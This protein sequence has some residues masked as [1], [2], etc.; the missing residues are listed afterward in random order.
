MKR[1][2]QKG[3]GV[4]LLS[5]AAVST[6]LCQSVR[7]QGE[8]QDI[9][10]ARAWNGA[11]SQGDRGILWNGSKDLNSLLPHEDRL[12]SW[13]ELHK[14]HQEKINDWIDRQKRWEELRQ[15]RI[16]T[17]RDF[18]NMVNEGVNNAIETGKNFE[19]LKS[20]QL[21]T[22]RKAKEVLPLVWEAKGNT[23]EV[24]GKAYANAPIVIYDA[25]GQVIGRGAAAGDGTFSCRLYRPLRVGERIQ[26]VCGDNGGPSVFYVISQS[27]DSSGNIPS[28]LQQRI[29]YVKGYPDGTFRPSANVTRG[30][31]AMMLAT[32]VNGSA[33]F[34]TTYETPFRDANEQW[35]SSAINVVAQKGLLRGYP[36]GTFRPQNNMSRGEFAQ[37]VRGYLSYSGDKKVFFSDIEG[38]WAK[39]AIEEMAGA[40]MIQGYPDQTFRPD[41]AITRA[42]AVSLLNSCFGRITKP[43][44][45]EGSHYQIKSFSDVPISHWAYYSIIDAA[46]NHKSYVENQA[47]PVDIWVD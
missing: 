10:G 36:D 2:L 37:M 21:D 38:H 4:F 6:F 20:K 15:K 43:R 35:Y 45:L 30:E 42:E 32:L 13:E 29:A 12:T 26:I 8:N 14:R 31:A 44:S 19:E 41:R 47:N 5:A 39:K 28:S 27:E 7:A 16:E 24:Y 11:L 33:F 46:T 17:L 1:K 40:G 18:N 9:T 34:E 3:L 25:Q 23:Y 22:L